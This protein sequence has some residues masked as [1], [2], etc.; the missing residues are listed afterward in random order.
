[1]D[2]VDVTDKEL[3]VKR[4]RRTSAAIRAM[5]MEEPFVVKTSEGADRVGEAGDYL[6][7]TYRGDRYPMSREEFEDSY[8]RVTPDVHERPHER[9]V[10]VPVSWTGETA[11]MI[12]DAIVD[13]FKDADVDQLPHEEPDVDDNEEVFVQYVHIEAEEDPSV[14]R[15]EMIV[16]EEREDE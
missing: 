15:V 8:K 6:V 12:A 16:R 2:R 9:R 4:Y 13:A 5:Q 1:M 14:N 7:E 10:S 11:E 3:P